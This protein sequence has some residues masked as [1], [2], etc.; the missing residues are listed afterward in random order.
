MG[1]LN[2][3]VAYNFEEATWVKFKLVGGVGLMLL[4]V[5]AQ[6]VFLARHVQEEK[7]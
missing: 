6:A 4:F 1:V 3:Y 5:L 7:P 2:L